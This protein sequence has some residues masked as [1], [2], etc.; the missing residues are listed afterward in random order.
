M[1]DWAFDLQGD[2]I[3]SEPDESRFNPPDEDEG[4][5]QREDQ[6]DTAQEPAEGH[7]QRED[8]DDVAYQAFLEAAP[9]HFLDLF[10]QEV[11]VSPHVA[12]DGH[13]YELERILEWFAQEMSNRRH[14]HPRSPCTREP[15]RSTTLY[16][17]ENLNRQ[18]REFFEANGYGDRLPA[19]RR[20][21]VAAASSASTRRATRSTPASSSNQTPGDIE[22]ALHNF[23]R[24]LDF[25]SNGLTRVGRATL[26]EYALVHHS[27]DGIC[28]A[29]LCFRQTGLYTQKS[30]V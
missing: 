23:L 7:E 3:G 28:H 19:A 4:H 21:P 1:A 30:S 2:H 16:F 24:G 25:L 29:D 11:M 26:V 22:A 9:E 27:Q 12:S 15:L 10:S 13:S 17:N 6:D 8:Q 20:H 5:E 14:A 18:I